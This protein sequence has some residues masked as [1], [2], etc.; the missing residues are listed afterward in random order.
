MLETFSNSLEKKINKIHNHTDFC[1]DEALQKVLHKLLTCHI[2]YFLKVEMQT[3]PTKRQCTKGK[4]RDFIVPAVNY[5]GKICTINVSI[6]RQ[7][8][9]Y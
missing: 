4:N 2:I 5:S 6:F 3:L 1:L 9:N 7:G 8:F